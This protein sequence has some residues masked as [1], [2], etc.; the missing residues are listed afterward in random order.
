[1]FFTCFMHKCT[2]QHIQHDDV[3]LYYV[4]LLKKQQ[5]KKSCCASIAHCVIFYDLNMRI[6]LQHIYIRLCN[7]PNTIGYYSYVYDFNVLLEGVGAFIS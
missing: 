1:M 3:V 4:K 2:T 5:M 6:A 7:T